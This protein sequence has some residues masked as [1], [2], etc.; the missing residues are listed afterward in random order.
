M[1]QHKSNLI[2]LMLPH[3][4]SRIVPASHRT[5]LP[6]RSGQDR[7]VVL[8]LI[9]PE[10]V[11]LPARGYRSWQPLSQRHPWEEGLAPARHHRAA[12]KLSGGGNRR[13]S[14]QTKGRTGIRW[15]QQ[16][17]ASR[18]PKLPVPFRRCHETAGSASQWEA[19]SGWRV[20]L[21]GVWSLQNLQ[22]HRQRAPRCLCQGFCLQI[23]GKKTNIS[24]PYLHN[25]K[26]PEFSL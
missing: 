19:G 22:A 4:C 6:P 7:P 25:L 26:S 5:P 12:W 11:S 3:I 24:N 13:D 9:L 16:L 14:T 18:P 17:P 23:S 8:I 10:T 1:F 15:P 20:R 21:R 2:S